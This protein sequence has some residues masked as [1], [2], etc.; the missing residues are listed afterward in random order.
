VS[1]ITTTPHLYVFSLALAL[2]LRINNPLN[3]LTCFGQPTR[4]KL[5]KWVRCLC[6]WTSASHMSVGEVVMPSPLKQAVTDKKRQYRV[7]LNNRPPHAISFMAA[8]PGTTGHL[9]CELVCL[10]FLRVSLRGGAIQQIYCFLLQ[11]FLFCLFVLSLS[12][13]FLSLTP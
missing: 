3:L 8:V 10:L 7:D 9:H 13:L 1:L 12:F 11:H 2:P 6:S 4:L 5:N